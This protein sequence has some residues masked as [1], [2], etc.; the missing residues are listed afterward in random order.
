M[1]L[2]QD[3]LPSSGRS[4]IPGRRNNLIIRVR[5]ANK[6]FLL[7]LNLRQ[8]RYLMEESCLY[9][10]NTRS[11]WWVSTVIVPRFVHTEQQRMRTF[12]WKVRRR[13]FPKSRLLLLIASMSCYI[14]HLG[15]NKKK[16]TTSI[17]CLLSTLRILNTIIETFTPFSHS[18]WQGVNKPSGSS[19]DQK[20][21]H[22]KR[23]RVS[24]CVCSSNHKLFI[25]QRA[26]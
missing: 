24:S 20:S 3:F 1:F 13:S 14:C 9:L 18:F 21:G 19:H 12:S 4:G 26:T 25:K 8:I 23:E 7:S 6:L 17:L 16:K 11:R 2:L 10:I 22:W 15:D 5:Q